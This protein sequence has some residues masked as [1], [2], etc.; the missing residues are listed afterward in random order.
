M[1]EVI[2]NWPNV[3]LCY[4]DRTGSWGGFREFR[5]IEKGQYGYRLTVG[6]QLHAIRYH[7]TNYDIFVNPKVVEIRPDGLVVTHLMEK[8]GEGPVFC[9]YQK[10]LPSGG[11]YATRDLYI[12]PCEHLYEKNK[13]ADILAGTVRD[14]D[15]RKPWERDDYK[16]GRG[17]FWQ[18]GGWRTTGDRISQENLHNFV[19][20]GQQKLF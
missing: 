10:E 5:E 6:Q 20:L 15:P 4:M 1:D 16:R 7:G 8:N 19:K 14:E 3:S 13:L 9:P 2:L 18:H 11:V 17:I 12:E